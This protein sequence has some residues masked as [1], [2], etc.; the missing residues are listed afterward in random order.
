MKFVFAVLFVAMIGIAIGQPLFGFKLVTLVGQMLHGLTQ[1]DNPEYRPVTALGRAWQEAILGERV[2]RSESDD[3]SQF[4][5]ELFNER[6][7][8]QKREREAKEQFDGYV[9]NISSCQNEID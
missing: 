3:E 8:E 2:D 9:L 1:L 4:E 7:E 5:R 6:E